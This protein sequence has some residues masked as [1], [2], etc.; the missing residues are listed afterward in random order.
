M[1]CVAHRGYWN[2]E[3]PENTVEA[4]K[5]AYDFGAEAFTCNHYEDAFLWAKKEGV[6]LNPPR[7]KTVNRNER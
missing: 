5:R 7:T 3:I 2:A 6:K 1:A 4:I